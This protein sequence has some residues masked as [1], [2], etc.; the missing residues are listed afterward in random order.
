MKKT[1]LRTTTLALAAMLVLGFA[2]ISQARGYDD[3]AGGPRYNAP[4]SPEQRE[5]AQSIFN[6]HYAKMDSVRQ[7]LITKRAELDAQ[8]SS[9]S[10]DKGKIESLS[11]EIGEL[12][13]KMLAARVDLRAQ[14]DKE[15]LPTACGH[16]GP[17][18]GHMGYDHDM[19]M[20]HGGH[21]H[22][23][24]GGRGGCWRQGN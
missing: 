12:R 23:G 15:G 6:S 19:G 24:Y 5:K 4:L 22:G 11:K 2:G 14:L 20:R 13:G 18:Y 3:C 21:G 10:P 8:M 9:P 17:G 16:M 7:A 1:T